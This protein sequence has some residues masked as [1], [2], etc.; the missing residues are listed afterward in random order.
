ML[1]ASVYTP[2]AGRLQIFHPKL[3]PDV[4]LNIWLEKLTDGRV[5]YHFICTELYMYPAPI[6]HQTLNLS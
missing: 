5:K 6:P 2:H 1:N 3:F 4:I